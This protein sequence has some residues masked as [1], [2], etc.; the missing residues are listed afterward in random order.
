MGGNDGS[1]GAAGRPWTEE[2]ASIIATIWDGIV[3]VA[4]IVGAMASVLALL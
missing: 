4:Q 1:E 3:D 2:E